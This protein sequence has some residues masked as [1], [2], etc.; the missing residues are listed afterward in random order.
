MVRRLV[1]T[2]LSVPLPVP[3]ERFRKGPLRDGAFM[4]RLHSERLAARLGMALGVSFTI[5]M[6]TGLISHGLQQTPPWL[7]LPPR[8]VDLYRINQGLHTLTGIAAVPLLLAKLYTVYPRLFTWPPARDVGHGVERLSLLFL[9]GGSLVQIATGVMNVAGWYAFGFFF[10]A[11]H[12]WSAWVVIGS[13][14]VHIG[15]KLTQTRRA[16]SRAGRTADPEPDGPGLSRRGFLMAAGT[17]SG[18]LVVATA[19]QTVAPLSRL[20]VL[21]PR[22]PET[23]PQSVPVNKT[24]QAARIARV[25]DSYRLLLTGRRQVALSLDD[26]APCVSAPPSYPSRASRGGAPVRRGPA[27]RSGSC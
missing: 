17:A 5:C 1:S 12:Y 11:V 22:V 15:A 21:A 14:V 26:L 25:D 8:P 13:L 9:V 6:V 18:V 2:L 27:S 20:S 3:P 7:T 16:L 10:T 19:G 4:S 23:G 24:A